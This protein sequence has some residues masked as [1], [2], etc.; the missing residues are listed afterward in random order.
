M[1]E[2]SVINKINKELPSIIGNSSEIYII[3]HKTVD[4]DSIGAALGM[5]RLCRKYI[6]NDR[7][8]I[9]LNDKY[10]TLEPGLKRI[11]YESKE[12]YN[13]IDLNEFYSR[14]KMESPTLLVVDTNRKSLIDLKDDL[15]GFGNIIVIDHHNPTQDSIETKYCFIDPNSSSACEIV[16]RLLN[17][18]KIC[19][20][21]NIATY[22][23]AGIMLDTKR[24]IKNTTS[25][26]MD[27]A[28]KLLAKGADY[29]KINDLFLVDF[30]QDRKINDLIFNN[31]VFEAYDYGIPRNI[32]YTFNIYGA[33][34]IYRREELGRA[35]DKMLKYRV[36]AVFVLGKIDENTIAI[37]AR[38][39]SDVNVGAIMEQLGGG[40]N[41]QNAGCQIQGENMLEISGLLRETVK[42]NLQ[43]K[44]A[45]E[46]DPKN[47][48]FQY[49]KK[50][51]K[52]TTK[53][54]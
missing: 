8:F 19:Y 10:E 16:A 43:F 41:A 7:I 38:S 5:A 48:K 14:E 35:A 25:K 28:E 1:P 18:N 4:F 49:V 23:L 50:I 32:S 44:T 31:T 26:T 30:E 46:Q 3:G 52:K 2:L 34:A 42:T 33:D 17:L 53:K 27:T 12:E 54:D 37:S 39:K 36:D 40:G 6:D 45:M 47:A 20:D 29:N 51:P 24:Y 15:H 9:V 13:I 11:K 21:K 22:L